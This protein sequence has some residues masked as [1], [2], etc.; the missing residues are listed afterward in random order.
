M[1]KE[2]GISLK[3]KQGQTPEPGRQVTW[4]KTRDATASKSGGISTPWNAWPLRCSWSRG[5]ARTRSGWAPSSRTHWR[6]PGWRWCCSHWWTRARQGEI[7][8]QSP[9]HLGRPV[10]SLQIRLVLY[11]DQQNSRV[12]LRSKLHFI[13]LLYVDGTKPNVALT[14]VSYIM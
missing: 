11:P 4:V 7:R 10:D 8:Q 5:R 1:V 14:Y 13:G 12:G 9:P 6:T 2:I 3:K